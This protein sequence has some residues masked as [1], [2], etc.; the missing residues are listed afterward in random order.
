MTS[1]ERNLSVEN[2]KRAMESGD[3]SKNG[4]SPKSRKSRILDY[5][6]IFMRKLL[7]FIGCLITF[8]GAMK[9]QDVI[10]TRNNKRIRAIVTEV[11]DDKV[12]Y[13]QYSN[14]NGA[15]YFIPVREVSSIRYED[16]YT[17]YFEDEY[18]EDDYN[19]NRR[20]QPASRNA[21]RQ[22]YDEYEDDYDTD[23][24]PSRNSNS[25]VSSQRYYDDDGGYDAYY[26]RG[27]RSSRNQPSVTDWYNNQVSRSMQWSFRAGLNF[28]TINHEGDDDFD[29]F[30]SKI[31]FNLGIL[32]EVPFNDILGF[33]TGLLLNTRGARYSEKDDDYKYT[34]SINIYE[35]QLPAYLTVGF[36]LSDES[37][38]RIKFHAGPTLGVGLSAKS[39]YTE[40]YD[41][42]KDS[43]SDNLY[44]KDDDGDSELK[45]FNLCM[46]IGGGVEFDRFYI[47]IANDFGLSNLNG[48]TYE[49]DEAIKFNSFMINL[50]YAF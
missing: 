46:T 24:R 20:T 2:S 44:E 42:D 5:K 35:L 10:V 13:K 36:W 8:A 3:H 43:D 40:T 31:S 38:A 7:I 27:N 14:P 11:T 33:Q 30:G 22:Q 32:G 15:T 26:D 50:G 29:D 47:G 34:E 48:Y 25:R 37:N 21:R 6:G 17:D 12:R 28:N 18:I 41:G 23:R 4:A 49:D 16:G 45:R 19:D 1:K 9:A 39:K